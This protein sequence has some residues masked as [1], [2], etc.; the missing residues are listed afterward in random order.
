M[1]RSRLGPSPTRVDP[2]L[3]R[4]RFSKVPSPCHP[5]AP[6]RLR[7]SKVPS[8]SLSEFMNFRTFWDHFSGKYIVW[9][10]L[11]PSTQQ[12]RSPKGAHSPA[13]V[14]CDL[15]GY[16]KGGVGFRWRTES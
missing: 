16:R 4:L 12:V 13:E 10:S 7:F 3:L 8:P 2:S 1:I 6:S 5:F 11:G 9:T 15:S 14:I